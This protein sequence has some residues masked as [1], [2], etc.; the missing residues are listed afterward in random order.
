MR[1]FGILTIAMLC[2]ALL[3]VASAGASVV[4]A[5]EGTSC[6]AAPAG[7]GAQCWGYRGRGQL[8]D[9][10]TPAGVSMTYDPVQ[11]VGLTSGVTAVT[12]TGQGGGAGNH[13]CAIVNGG[14]QCWGNGGNGQLG[15]GGD[16][17]RNVPVAVTG[18]G[19]GVTEIDTNALK[20]CAI[21]GG[22]A[23]CWGTISKLFTG[24]ATEKAS[25]P[26]DVIDGAGALHV[27]TGWRHSCLVVAGGAVHCR[28]DNTN[29]QLGGGTPNVG[30]TPSKIVAGGDWNCVL[31]GD[32]VKCWGVQAV[33]GNDATDNSATPVTPTG[34]GSGV[35]DIDG[36]WSHACAIKADGTA[37]CWGELGNGRL[38]D[39]RPINPGIGGTQGTP[40]QVSGLTNVTAIATGARHTCAI[41]G[42]S[43]RWCWGSNQFGA[44]GNEAV[45][46]GQTSV[47]VRTLGSTP[48]AP[49][50]AP[51]PKP[52]VVTPPVVKPPVVKPVAPRIT[53]S[54]RARKLSRSRTVTIA[55][56]SCPATATKACA[57]KLA[58]TVKVTIKRKTYTLTVTAPKSVKAGRKV[59][60]TVKLSRSAA[61]RLKDRTATVR[62]SIALGTTRTTVSQKITA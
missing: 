62:L 4:S 6:A 44:L 47:P 35:V 56:L 41:V 8:G 49:T 28:G 25:V 39:G 34:L 22:N 36:N 19:S 54:T 24:W 53:W 59:S 37:W 61:K 45:E 29:G 32:G 14:A 38:G 11:P 31:V 43:E 30:G 13:S 9:G 3:G 15:D 12:Q 20:T 27:A 42:A 48:K 16:A 33:L 51:V 10:P 2:S 46:G 18:L 57:V 7:G 1:L 21:V 26:T 23:K 17:D 58:K 55:T 52:P 60:V 40:V 50:P 5:G